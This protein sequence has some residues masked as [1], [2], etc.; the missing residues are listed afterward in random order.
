MHYRNYPDLVACQTT[1]AGLS[2][3]TRLFDSSK[4]AGANSKVR[5]YIVLVKR[6]ELRTLITVCAS[7]TVEKLIEQL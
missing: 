5:T 4:A 6:F 7:K 2:E 1:A 3:R